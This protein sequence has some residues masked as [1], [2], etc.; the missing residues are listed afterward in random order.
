MNII[1]DKGFPKDFDWKKKLI[2]KIESMEA[3]NS[4]CSIVHRG[5]V[6]EVGDTNDLVILIGPGGIYFTAPG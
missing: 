5:V 6:L 1:I 2:E 3:D 4:V